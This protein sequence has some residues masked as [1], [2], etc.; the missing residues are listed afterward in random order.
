[1]KRL[2][3]NWHVVVFGIVVSLVVLLCGVIGILFGELNNT[4]KEK[5]QLSLLLNKAL[6][7]NTSLSLLLTKSFQQ[8]KQLSV[9]WRLYKSTPEC[10]PGWAQHTSRCCFL[11]HEAEKWEV[12]RRE[13]RDM[14]ADL[15]VV[16]NAKDQAFFIRLTFLFVQR[17]P[18]A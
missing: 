10:L 1:M 17:H 2:R 3:A 7:E 18:E 11:S 9:L 6:L 5:T 4:S 12:A 8:K 15:S 14:G 16:L 13:S